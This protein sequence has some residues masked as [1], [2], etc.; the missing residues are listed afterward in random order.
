[1]SDQDHDHDHEHG[2]GAHEIDNMPSRRLFNILFG[3]SALTLLACIGVVQLFYSQVKSMQGARHEKE[4]FQLAEYRQEMKDLREQWGP[5]WMTD[6][7]GVPAQERGKG[8]HEAQR[9]HMP[10]A[11]ARKRV[12]AE[13]GKALKA[14]RAYRGWRNPDP[15][16]PKAAAKPNPRGAARAPARGA[17]MPLQPGVRPGAKPGAQPV[18]PRP[19]G[20]A[21]PAGAGQPPV[22]GAVAPG[23]GPT[24]AAGAK[25]NPIPSPAKPEGKAPAKPEGKAPAKAPAKPEGKA[26]AKAGQ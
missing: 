12:L 5:V 20:A 19:R 17:R 22:K 23:K 7:D 9:F 14:G 25:P 4:S 6:D 11:E 21:S 1:M 10:L 18:A 16:A 8:V 13:P 15:K 26:P 2:D 3:I 24:G